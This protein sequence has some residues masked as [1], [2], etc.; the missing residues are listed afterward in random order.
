[1]KQLGILTTFG[2]MFYSALVS[3]A[4]LEIKTVKPFQSWGSDQ[5]QETSIAVKLPKNFHL[6]KDQLKVL[7]IKPDHFKSGEIKLAPEVEF[8]DKFSNKN[9]MGLVNEG[10]ISVLLVEKGDT[11]DWNVDERDNKFKI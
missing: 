4:P 6:Y 7:N 1:M 11:W 8:F 3:S 2:L 9:R 10:S 5:I